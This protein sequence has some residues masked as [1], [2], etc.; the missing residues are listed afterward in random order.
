MPAFNGLEKAPK[1]FE[2]L[3]EPV[4]RESVR[5]ATLAAVRGRPPDP[6]RP[7]A[8]EGVRRTLLEPGATTLA[9]DKRPVRSAFVAAAD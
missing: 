9:A 5:R 2:D 6:R 7:A 1:A 4:A 3:P 8:L